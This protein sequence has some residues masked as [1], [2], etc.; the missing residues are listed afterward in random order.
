MR[1]PESYKQFCVTAAFLLCAASVFPGVAVASSGV[2]ALS[3]RFDVV[4]REQ[5]AESVLEELARLIGVPV[6][7]SDEVDGIVSLRATSATGREIFDKVA[8]EAG[9]DW[10]YDGRRIEI[11]SQTE[12]VSRALSLGGVKRERLIKALDDAGL[13]DSKFPIKTVEDRLAIVSGPPRYVAVIEV[14]LAELAQTV[15]EEPA[16]DPA[17]LARQEQA[18]RLELLREEARIR[19]AFA[20]IWGVICLKLLI[21]HSLYL[22]STR[23]HLPL[24]MNPQR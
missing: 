1:V 13:Y 21:L 20:N 19:A 12:Q 9:L 7:L 15:I 23:L 6:V 24:W 16:V 4:V 11:T 14:V 18:A 8:I 22:I 17:E 2:A 3:E 5:N 10:R